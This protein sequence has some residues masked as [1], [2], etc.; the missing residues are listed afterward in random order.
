[1]AD[2]TSDGRGTEGRAR[3]WPAGGREG[4]SAGKPPAA[5]GRWLALLLAVAPTLALAL[6][7]RVAERHAPDDPQGAVAD[8]AGFPLADLPL[9]AQGQ[10]SA[11]LGRDRPSYHAVPQAGGFRIDNTRHGLSADFGPEAVRVRAGDVSWGLSL[12]GCGYGDEPPAAE[13]ASP[14]ASANRVE[15]RRGALT[16]WYLNGPLGLEQGFTLAAAPGRS[17]GEPLTLAF[18]LSGNVTASV[19]ATGRD[20]LLSR[21]DG[22]AALR[23]RGLTAHDATGRALR[24]WLEVEGERLRVRVDDAGARYP[25]VVDPFIEQATLI[26][27]DGAAGDRFGF[28]A[29]DGD[30]IVVGA[31]QDDL[32]ANADQGSAYVFAKPAGGWSGLLTEQARLFASDGAAGD[33]FGIRVAV[34]GDT[35]VLGAR[36]DDILSGTTLAAD[37]GSAYVFVKPPGGWSG[38]LYQ[39]A[40]LTASAGAANDWF[41][42]S[43]AIDGDTIVVGA[44]LAD[45]PAG[46]LFCDQVD[47]G[48]AYVFVR[49]AAGW[50]GNLTQNA[51]LNPWPIGSFQE[52]GSS[53]AVAGETIAVGA[54]GDNFERGNAY[55]FVRPTS[56]W[57]GMLTAPAVLVASDGNASDRFGGSVAVTGDTVV[58]GALLDD[59]GTNVDQGSAYVFT[60]PAGGWSGSLTQNA[61]LTASDGAARD[62]FGLPVAVSG[63]RVVV[64]ARWH[65][66]GASADQGSVYV[67]AR[68]AGG[69][70]GAVSE[71]QELTAAAGAASDLFG[72][73]LDVDGDTIVVGATGND[74]GTSSRPGSAHV[75]VAEPVPVAN[76]GPDQTVGEGTLVALDGRAST[77]G[78]ATFT[79]QQLAGRLVVLS[80]P[81]SRTPS[82]TAP[83]LD[84][85]FGSQVLTFQLTVTGGGG[86][87]SDTVDVT[88]VNVNRAPVADAGDDQRVNEGSPVALRSASYDRDD[89]PIA[90]QWIQTDGRWVELAGADSATPSFTA[91][92]LDG[93]T[94]GPEILAFE[95]TVSDGA[96]AST[97]TVQV[98]VEQVNHPPEANAGVDQTADEGA[99][100]ALDG[101]ASSDP[102]GDPIASFAWSQVGGPWVDL[103]G[104]GG[105]TPSFTAPPVGPGGAALVF[106]LAVS[107]GLLWS[108][109][110]DQVTVHVVDADD[111]P[112]CHAARPSVA[113]LWPPNH[114]MVPVGITGVTDPNGDGVAIAITGVTQDEPVNG[115]GDGDTSPDAVLQG[116][117]VL[118]RAE[119]SGG[120]NGRVYRLDFTASNAGGSCTGRVQ[121][122]VPRSMKDGGSALDDGA[123][124]DATLP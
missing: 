75:F 65:D 48:S 112:L 27:S 3:L 105:A 122:Q 85:G 74:A 11:T 33:L 87:S 52:F 107:D 113:R 88:V 92:F 89:D 116:D 49:P 62:Q 104:A 21:S 78:S 80:D 26:P 102:D 35:I 111:P 50:S 31:P 30:T 12:V 70:S 98:T 97:D 25:L 54:W 57:S 2:T 76:A 56:G 115:L 123:L 43:V 5:S 81:A 58:V 37:R 61:K 79:W 34:S 38:T 114:K 9:A 55:A 47:R 29:M 22:T 23:Y 120:G 67:F 72:T 124:H 24:A 45:I 19:D 119:R 108:K 13:A 69:W 6:D 86:S 60:R 44:R 53:V 100:V 39:S 84:G 96:L 64:G 40:K 36:G 73:S 4:K 10:V 90:Y 14:Q 59:V 16:E 83:L 20:L 1:M 93:G 8:P 41:G 82:F 117:R 63:E 68:P 95:L 94:G 46:C 7:G 121:V 77:G 17:A 51:T 109:G 110:P 18:G 99:S 101:S 66:V 91:P 118:L 103:S 32:G 15:Y 42:G 106:E 28:V 71:Q